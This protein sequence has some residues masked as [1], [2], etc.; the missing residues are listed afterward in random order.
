L[1]KFSNSNNILCRTF[2]AEAEKER[3]P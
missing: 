1:K 3:R 2:A